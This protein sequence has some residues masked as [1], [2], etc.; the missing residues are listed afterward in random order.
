SVAFGCRRHRLSAPG[1]TGRQGARSRTGGRIS[2]HRGSAGHCAGPDAN[3][4]VSGI[5]AVAVPAP[6]GARPRTRWSIAACLVTVLGTAVG[7]AVLIR[8]P[9]LHPQQRNGIL[10][11]PATIPPDRLGGALP[12]ARRPDPPLRPPLARAPAP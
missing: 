12:L 3:G 6:T 9:H 11:T 2:R 5:A 10:P 7:I 4:M 8:V 1:P